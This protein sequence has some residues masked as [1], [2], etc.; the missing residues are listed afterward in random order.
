MTQVSVL[1]ILAK[2]A[3]LVKNLAEGPKFPLI[4][5]RIGERVDSFTGTKE[6][7]TDK[8]VRDLASYKTKV[9]LLDNL[10]SAIIMANNLVKVVVGGTEVTV[11]EAI[12]SRKIHQNTY[13][14]FIREAQ[15]QTTVV[16]NLVSRSL[17]DI[18]AQMDKQKTALS[19]GGKTAS[20][21]TL[22]SMRAD[23]EKANLREV[24]NPNALEALLAKYQESYEDLDQAFNMA[25]Q[26]ANA[27]VMVEVDDRG[28]VDLVE[29]R[30]RLTRQ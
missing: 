29:L 12:S 20:E 21:E 1:Q 2:K 3:N 24:V 17:M 18:E 28:F 11:A 13:S 4:G 26:E 30:T 5:S 22:R 19:T 8:M 9:H 14:A 7:F 23:V 25:I 6:D 27:K 16:N 15:R 10:N